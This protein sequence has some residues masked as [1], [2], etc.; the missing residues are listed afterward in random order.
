MKHYSL[1]ITPQTRVVDLVYFTVKDESSTFQLMQ[2]A[3]TQSPVHHISF[4]FQINSLIDI[5][6]CSNLH[7]FGQITCAHWKAT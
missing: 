4:T 1:L 3:A 2:L 5:Y 7:I 6:F